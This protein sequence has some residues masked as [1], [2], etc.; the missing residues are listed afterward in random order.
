MGTKKSLLMLAA[1]NLLLLAAAKRLYQWNRTVQIIPLGM[2]QS[3]PEDELNK[4]IKP[5]DDALHHYSGRFYW[6]WWYFDASFNDGSRCVLELQT[7]NL[8]NMFADECAM[9]FNVYLPDGRAYNNIVPFPGSM[10]KASTEACDVAIGENTIKGGYPE[11]HVSFKHENLACDL[12]FRNLLPGWT[13]GTGEVLFGDP[14]KKQVF[15]WVVA[16]PKASVTGTLTVDGEERKVSGTGYHDHNW[17]NGFLP[18]Y[19]SHWVWGRLATDRVNMIFADVC[20]SKKCGKYK[21]PVIF[22]AIDDRIVLESANARFEVSEYRFDSQGFQMYPGRLEFNFS[23]REISGSFRI[24]FKEELEMVN[25]L[26]EKIPGPLVKIMGKLL[27]APAYYRFL[28]DYEG[29]IKRGDEVLNLCGETHWEYMVLGL[30][31]GEI[32]QG[33]RNI[34]HVALV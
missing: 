17:G 1:E 12:V 7:P 16:Q 22:L 10:W 25:T 19:V 20:T 26:A 11:Y 32:P 6:E 27:S 21:I 8:V 13:R 29:T 31:K 3:R 4:G 9:L 33:W 15:G 18:A 14:E 5:E 28:A 30:K 23:E 34:P 24:L 2:F